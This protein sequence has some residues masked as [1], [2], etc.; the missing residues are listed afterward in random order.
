MK[1]LLIP[2]LCVTAVRFACADDV[3]VLSIEFPKEKHPRQ[4]VFE[5]HDA[6][7]PLTVENF[8]RLA[9]KKFYKGV[10]FHR[11][12]PHALVQ[13]GD[14]Q[15]KKEKYRARTGTGGPGYTLPPE[16]KGRHAAGAVAMVRLP[17]KLNP[18]RRSNGS[19]FFICLKPMPEYDGKYTVFGH[20]IGGMD[21][22]DQISELPVDSNDN[23]TQRVVIRSIKI[24][25]REKVELSP[26][27]IDE[28]KK[29]S[30]SFWQRLWKKF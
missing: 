25:P 10:A 3:A 27:K 28:T 8:K 9:K 17:D 6:E 12:F 20:V 30:E 16:I 13:T 18:S 11:V 14:P 15:S 7:A 29:S 5:F 23:P 19:Q 24:E 1:K 2:L 4:A 22:L 21:V 26:P